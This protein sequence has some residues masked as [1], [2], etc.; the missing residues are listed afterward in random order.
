MGTARARAAGLVTRPLRETLAAALEYEETRPGEERR[1]GLTDD[2]ERRVLAATATVVGGERVSR[3]VPAATESA[4]QPTSAR[5]AS[6][7]GAAPV[8][9]VAA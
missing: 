6:S 8:D 7:S 1:A 2:D 3:R 4:A 9:A 5:P